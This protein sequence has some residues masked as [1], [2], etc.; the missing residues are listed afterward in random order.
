MSD[1]LEGVKNLWI[2]LNAIL[3]AYAIALFIYG[4][5]F[6]HKDSLSLVI[7]N[8]LILFLFLQKNIADDNKGMFGRTEDSIRINDNKELDEKKINLIDE[9]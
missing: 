3:V 7:N 2:A 1:D 9:K 5:Y 4:K 8:I 6:R